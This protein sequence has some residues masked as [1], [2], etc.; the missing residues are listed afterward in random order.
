MRYGKYAADRNIKHTAKKFNIKKLMATI[1]SAA[2]VLTSLPFVSSS[3]SAQTSFDAVTTA[4]LNL[5]TGAGLNYY[6]FKVMAPD[7]KLTVLDKSDPD[8]LKV[9]TSEGVLG[10]CDSKYVE[11]L[12]DCKTT[13][14]L[15][16]RTGAGTNNP[17]IKTFAPNT[18]LDIKSFCGDTWAKVADSSGKEGYICTDYVSYIA[19]AVQP[20]AAVSAQTVKSTAA[21]VVNDSTTAAVT[22][23]TIAPTAKRIP[24]NGKFNIVPTGN[25][26]TVTYS[27]SNSKVAYVTSKGAVRG[28]ALGACTIT[29][30]D[31]KT[32]K[33]AECKLRVMETDFLSVTLASEQTTITMGDSFSLNAVTEPKGKTVYYTS[34][35]TSIAKVDT[36]GVVTGLKTGTAKIT[37]ADSTG[38]AKSVCVVTVKPKTNITLSASSVAIYAG[39]SSTV[40]ASKY[41]STIAVKWTSSNT[42]IAAVNNG[43]ISGLRAGTATITASDASGSIKASCRVTVMGVSSGSVKLSRYTASATA[44]KTI[45]I[46]GYNG[47]SWESSDPNVA[48]VR[49]GFIQTKKAGSAAI[50]FKDKYGNKAICVVTVSNPAPVKFAYSSPNSATLGQKVTL[51]AITDKLRT[52]VSFQVNDGG[53]TRYIA[54]TKTAAEGN[55]YVWKGYYTPQNSGTLKV[56]TYAL[57]SG[58]WGT[59]QDG[60]TDIFVSAKSNASQVGLTR[61]RV[62]DPVIKFIGDNEGFVSS[63]TYDSLAGN[64]PTLGHGCVVWEGQNFYDN[65]TR[66]EAYALL[67]KTVNDDAFA[68]RVNDM[69]ISN[70]VYFN[71]QQFDALVSFSYNL[72][73][74][75]TYGSKLKDVVLNSYGIVNGKTVRCLNGINRT[76]FINEMLIIH[77]AGGVCYYGLLY[78]RADEV[79]MFLYGDY[80]HDGR[81]NKYKL[82]SPKC[83]SW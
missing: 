43:R 39:T 29:A 21:T 67:V 12:T 74:G 18:K 37:A 65:L 54:G 30:T 4:N 28:V 76:Q 59:C 25:K 51:T 15:N 63:I 9:K 75:W 5:R 81:S 27:S 49:A 6:S 16:F 36:K 45:Y 50:S 73:T 52:G 41:P 71:Q 48:T 3:V 46:K 20:A 80:V 23:F 8:W 77:H 61:L 24:L 31:T 38:Y 57:Y 26:G 55:T 34:S 22:E 64:I 66:S 32:G 33:T 60:V 68:K 62:S 58:Q 40:T 72:G 53:A 35:D 14:Y 17:V 11:I 70:G 2:V 47:S 44:G 42:S 13:A 82:P 1:C 10:Y 79:E 83:L 56:T 19:P 7:T 69:L 78:R